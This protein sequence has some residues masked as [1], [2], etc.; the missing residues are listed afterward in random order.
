MT[1]ETLKP[2][3]KIYIVCLYYSQLKSTDAKY[4]NWAYVKKLL[5]EKYNRKENTIKNDKDYYDA[6]SKDNGRSGWHKTDKRSKLA[7]E[8]YE[9]YKNLS[10]EELENMVKKIVAE[11]RNSFN[12]FAIKTKIPNT[13]QSI[14]NCEKEIV[15]D[16]INCYKENIHIGDLV[17]VVLGGDSSKPEVDWE[18]GLKGIGIISKEPYEQVGKNFKIKVEIRLLF[19]HPI[20]KYDLIHHAE[21]YDIS[22]IGVELKRDHTQAIAKLEHEQVK[23]L[24]RAI[25]DINSQT[26]KGIEELFGKDLLLLAKGPAKIYTESL[27]KYEESANLRKTDQSEI[28]VNRKIKEYVKTDFL[29]EVFV[30]DKFYESMVNLLENNKNII[31]QGAPGVGKT[32]IAEKLAHSILGETDYNLIETVQFHPSYSYEDFVMGYKPNGNGFIREKGVFYEFCEKAEKSNKKHFLIIDEINRGN[33]SKI[34]GELILLLEHTKRANKYVKLSYDKEKL[35]TIPENIYII[36]T[37]NTA[38]RSLSIIDY[39]LRRRFKF[40]TIKPAFDSKKFKNHLLNQGATEKQI[41]K[42]INNMENLNKKIKD[43]LGSGYEIG[44]SYFCNYKKDSDWYNKIIEYDIKPLIEEYWFDDESK[45]NEC[46]D[47]ILG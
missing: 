27:L 1:I 8:I 13:V 10:L 46:I 25:I 12:C 17:F 18:K 22:Y 36:G 42:I 5:S 30:D 11:A 38:D 21:T 9:K 24:I 40:I 37:M 33:I 3:E 15:F 41:D 20:T 43:S 47:E 32:F 45:A 14:I 4:K 6:L 26:E 35:F 29:K 7:K 39:A 31:L 23:A 19:N 16:N 44:H 28:I 2:I 34:F